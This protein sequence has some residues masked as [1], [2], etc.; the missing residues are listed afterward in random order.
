MKL[1]D[2]LSK[3]FYRMAATRLKSN[4]TVHASRRYG[5]H[6]AD[7]TDPGFTIIEILIVLL[8]AGLILSVIFLAVPALQRN[9]RNYSRMHAVDLIA[10]SLGEYSLNHGQCPQNNIEGQTYRDENPEISKQFYLYFRDKTAGHSDYPD[11]DEIFIVYEHWC[12]KYG[13]GDLAGDPIAGDDD[14][15]SLYVVYTILEPETSAHQRVYCVDNYDHH[16]YVPPA[17]P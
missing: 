15:P 5:S 4:F 16:P 1:S 14:V 9:E 7:V 12:N 13:N 11:M 2:P 6:S 8:I 10:A 17:G 3:S